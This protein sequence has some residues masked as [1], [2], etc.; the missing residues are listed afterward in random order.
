VTVRPFYLAYDGARA[1]ALRYHQVHNLAAGGVT[2]LVFLG[3]VYYL[4]LGLLWLI[5]R[6]ARQP[7]RPATPPVP[8]TKGETT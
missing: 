8:V 3:A 4:G 7:K 1:H 5:V 6:T 2:V